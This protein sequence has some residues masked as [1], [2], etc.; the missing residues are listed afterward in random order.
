MSRIKDPHSKEKQESPKSISVQQPEIQ[1]SAKA[2]EDIELEEGYLDLLVIGQDCLADSKEAAEHITEIIK[3]LGDKISTRANELNA[4][5]TPSGY[6]V[7]LAQHVSN[8]TAEDMETFAIR[9]EA[10]TPQFAKQYSKA[11]DAYSKA[12]GVAGNS[13]KIDENELSVSLSAVG[14]LKGILLDTRGKV[15]H[16]KEVISNLPPLTRAFIRSKKHA[17]AVLNEFICEFDT[18]INLTAEIEKIIEKRIES[19]REIKD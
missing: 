5:K 18:G 1:E 16:F 11:I 17:V 3:T 8:R 4:A 7:K 10:E 14:T 15:A 19:Q 13:L 6:N 12:Y 2:A 9:I